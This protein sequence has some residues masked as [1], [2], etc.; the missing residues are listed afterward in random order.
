MYTGADL[1]LEQALQLEATL[2]GLSASTADMK[3]GT[4]AFL[5]K[6]KPEFTGGALRCPCLKAPPP[7][8]ACALP[9]VVARF[10]D[11]V[12]ERLRVGAIEALTAAGVAG[13]HITTLRVPGQ[14]RDSARGAAR[15]G[16]RTV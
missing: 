16:D 10:N 2:F 5:E 1:P 9:I 11:F 8:P 14:L 4:R 12:T 13:E 3:E 6:R 15:R 7:P